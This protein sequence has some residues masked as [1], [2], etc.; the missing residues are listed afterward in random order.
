VHAM[1]GLLTTKAEWVPLLAALVVLV[2]ARQL[3]VGLAL[4]ALLGAGTAAAGMAGVLLGEKLLFV[5]SVPQAH[6]P[7]AFI[8][9]WRWLLP[10]LCGAGCA[11]PVLLR[12]RGFRRMEHA[13]AI[14][15]GAA[16][17]LL[18]LAWSRPL[19]H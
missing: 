3:R 17:L 15:A 6:N 16:L 7:V 11:L 10:L 5:I 2:A 19:L 12:W 18:G 13:D 8:G 1:A 14:L 4:A 9:R